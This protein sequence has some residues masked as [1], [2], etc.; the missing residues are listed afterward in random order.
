MDGG[1]LVCEGSLSLS[2]SR[3][4]VADYP[5]FR[6]FLGGLDAAIGRRISV[7]PSIRAPGLETQ[8]RE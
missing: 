2:G 3:V 8:A 6:A 7:T 4:K 5:A 1:A